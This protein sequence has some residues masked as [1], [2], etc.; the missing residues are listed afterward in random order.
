MAR[1]R[2]DDYLEKQQLILDQA[3]VLFAGKGFA[4]T[5]IA[6]IAE[7]CNASKALIYH[8]YQSKESMLFDMLYT[9]CQLL[10]ATAQEI[11]EHRELLPEQ[12]LRN[13]LRSFM[14]I[15][16]SARAK[17]VVLLNDLHWLP[18]LQQKEIREL[19]RQ[20]VDIFKE[21]VRAVRPCLS[22]KTV[23]ALSMSLMG[24]INW[25][26]IWFK[27]EGPLTAQ[28]FADITAGLFFAGIDS[29]DDGVDEPRPKQSGAL[30]E[31]TAT[32]KGP[33]PATRMASRKNNASSKIPN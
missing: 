26:Y 30:K 4:G 23:T 14:A 29:I 10:C 17:H 6:S 9:H 19:E 16:V 13:L 32:A 2:A 5:S 24:S 3:A 25:T 12:K 27:P 1:P 18:E 15:Y 31:R 7:S 33:S 21:L 11:M 8:Y 22:E 28:K 20:V